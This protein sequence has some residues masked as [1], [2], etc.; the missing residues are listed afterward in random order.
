[1]KKKSSKIS[2]D[3]TPHASPAHDSDANQTGSCFL[4]LKTPYTTQQLAKHLIDKGLIVLS[5]QDLV[6][7]LKKQGYYRLRGYWITLEKENK[8][9][10]VQQ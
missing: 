1:M 10:L 9:Y 7:T 5:E 8:F 3:S 4:S 6:A 2:I